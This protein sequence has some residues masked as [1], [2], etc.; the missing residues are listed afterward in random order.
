MR[1]DPGLVSLDD[2]IQGGRIDIA[3]L[4]QDRLQRAHAQLGLGEFRMVV[5]VVVMMVVVVVIMV[6]HARQDSRKIRAMSRRGL[7]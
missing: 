2:G 6:A 3:F 1:A 4:G 7:C 5:I